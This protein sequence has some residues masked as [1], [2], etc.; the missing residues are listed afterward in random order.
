MLDEI[1]NNIDFYIRNLTCFSR[2]NF[3]ETNPA[4]LERNYKENLYTQDVLDSFFEKKQNEKLTILDIGSKNWFYAKGEYNYFASF[5]SNFELDG[6]ELDAY[7]LYSNL[8]SRYEV[9]KYHIKDLVNTT[10]IAGNLL[11]LNKKYDYIIWFLPFVVITPHTAWGLP[12]RLFYPEKLLKHAYNLLKD[13]GQ[14]LIVNQ[15]IIEAEEQVKLFEK[16]NISYKELGEIKNEHF[17]YKNQRFG[18][19]VRK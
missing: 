18:Y 9:A 4:L 14:M 15:G 3:E 7:R 19:I 16:L 8:Y 13:N 1:R 6:I 10:Y 12:Q 5:C 2:K 17:E 11:D